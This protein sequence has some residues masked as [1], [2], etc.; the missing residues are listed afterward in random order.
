MQRR[1]SAV[2]VAA[3]RSCVQYGRNFARP[4]GHARVRGAVEATR[5]RNKGLHVA[6]S[7]GSEASKEA[8]KKEHK[9]VPLDADG[10]IVYTLVAS[11]SPSPSG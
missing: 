4:R 2:T 7:P 1:A 8:D 11:Y 6:D 3:E 5:T 10:V 9:G